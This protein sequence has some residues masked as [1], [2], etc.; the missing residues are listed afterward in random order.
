MILINISIAVPLLIAVG[1]T[2]YIVFRGIFGLKGQ[3]HD[4]MGEMSPW[5]SSL[6]LNYNVREPFFR[7]KIGRFKARVHRVALP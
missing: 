6:D 1:D 3:C 4:M 2:D 5:S 7:L